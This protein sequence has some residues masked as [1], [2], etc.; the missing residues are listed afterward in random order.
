MESFENRSILM[1]R[2]EETLTEIFVA[3]AKAK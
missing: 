3:K 1:I 2:L